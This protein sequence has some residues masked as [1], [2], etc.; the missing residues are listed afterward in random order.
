MPSNF[1]AIDQAEREV[2]GAILLRD[3]I[4]DEVATILVA[5]DFRSDAHRRVWKCMAD[6]F[7]SGR[8]IDG[9][10]VADSLHKRGEIEDVG[11]FGYIGS[12]VVAVESSVAAA[13]HAR[14]V[15][16][17]A[18]LR[19]LGSVGH[20]IAYE[21]EHPTDEAER[22]L[23][24]AEQQILAL[25]ELGSEGATCSVKEVVSDVL[26]RL[27][28]REK[29][30]GRLSGLSTGLDDLN[31]ILGG[32]QSSE[33]VVLA[34]RPGVGKTAMAA[35]L[36]AHSAIVENVP[37]FFSS[38]EMSRLELTERLLCIRARVSGQ[39]LRLGIATGEELDRLAT[40][41]EI[42]SSAPIYIDDA[43][44]QSMLRIAANARRHRR[45]HGLGLVI[46]DYLQLIEPDDR[47]APR[48][49]QVGAISRRLKILARDIALPVVALAQ[50]NR[51]AENRA[52]QRPR[53]S[54]LR[55]SGSIEADADT[56]ILMHKS[57]EQSDRRGQVV[58]LLVEK[59]RNGPTGD[60][61]VRFHPEQ[62]RFED[63]TAHPF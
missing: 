39:H 27:D 44:R 33:L 23:E 56:V 25:G 14:I 16:S 54:D 60:V 32:F 47:R 26:K 31:G 8:T 55:E 62:L 48:H 49:E 46:V 1:E 5:E 30:R 43:P 35:C 24:S 21:A 22:V 61:A 3:S 51:E 41:A 37:V 34:A 36:A 38:L 13:Q 15:H 42:V 40:A 6:L 17:Q 59:Q 50:L 18:L 12:L 28:E 58:S 19:R 20:R 57:A 7:Q 45:K 53:L 9:T 2:L 52:G 63:L 11:G 29:R 10:S 4:F